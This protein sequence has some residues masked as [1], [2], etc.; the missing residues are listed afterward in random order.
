MHLVNASGNNPEVD[1]VTSTGVRSATVAKKTIVEMC[2]LTVDKIH[3]L[4]DGL[5][6]HHE[7]GLQVMTLRDFCKKHTVGERDVRK[8]NMCSHLKNNYV[9]PMFYPKISPNKEG[10]DYYKHCIRALIKHKP[11]TGIR[12]TAHGGDDE[13]KSKIVNLWENHIQSVMSSCD[14]PP[15]CLQT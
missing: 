1:T 13:D 8:N 4:N 6:N 15:D 10:D 12:N 7:S 3:W 5:C 9:M 14:M 2:G 11:W